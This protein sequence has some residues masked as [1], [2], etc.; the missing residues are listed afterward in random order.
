L[1]ASSEFNFQQ[2]FVGAFLRSGCK[3]RPLILI[4]KHLLKFNFQQLFVGAF[5]RSGCK[6][7]PLISIC[8]HL[9]KFNFQR[10]SVGVF[11]RSGRKCRPLIS[12]CKH[13]LKFNFQR[14][15]VG[16][17]LRS[18]CKCRPLILT[19]KH[20]FQNKSMPIFN[21][22]HISELRGGNR[23]RNHFPVDETAIVPCKI[24]N[25]ACHL[26]WLHWRFIPWKGFS[27]HLSLHSTKG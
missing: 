27:K 23:Y 7:R 14:L 18:G 20:L 26:L 2:L 1:Q 15:F 13:L 17:F 12:I 5:F 6:C 3:C 25:K 24:G 16:V 9:L 8:K 10:L 19:C 11:L 4:C 22:F 21:P